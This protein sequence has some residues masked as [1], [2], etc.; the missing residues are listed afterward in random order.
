MRRMQNI[1][2]TNIRNSFK[3][4]DH[5]YYYFYDLISQDGIELWRY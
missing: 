5:A 4:A 1:T 3:N 2:M